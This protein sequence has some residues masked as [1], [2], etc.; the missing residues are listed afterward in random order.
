M[1][2]NKV[3]YKFSSI[4]RFDIVVIKYDGD[5][6]IKRVIGLPGDK[7]EMQNNKLYINDKAYDETYLASGTNTPNFSVMDI[8]N[9]E[10]IPEG[11]YLVLGDN[12]EES[13]DSRSIGLIKRKDIKGKA[14]LTIFPFTRIGIKN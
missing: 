1:I 3:T 5:L 10:T 12:R 9:T 7:V 2:L 6:I 14:S 13:K 11:Y 8:N 4:T